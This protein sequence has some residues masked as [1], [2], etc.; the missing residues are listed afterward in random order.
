MAS[1]N[2]VMLQIETIKLQTHN[3][4]SL[5]SVS[6]VLSHYRTLK[7]HS[8]KVRTGSQ[9]YLTWLYKFTALWA[10][11]WGKFWSFKQVLEVLCLTSIA[12]WAA[13][14]PAVVFHGLQ[15]FGRAVFV[16]CC[17]PQVVI[18]AQIERANGIACK[19]QW[20]AGKRSP[21][22]VWKSWLIESERCLQFL[23]VSL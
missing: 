7:Y 14:S 6:Y 17:K 15:Y 10:R 1:E 22:L 9:A 13:S 18:G 19:L 4:M 23:K 8:Q 3:F 12:S 21:R 20:P 2:C 5:V 16:S 11:H